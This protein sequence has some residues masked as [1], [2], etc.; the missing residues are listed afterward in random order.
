MNHANSN[1]EKHFLAKE[2]HNDC[3]IHTKVEIIT[4]S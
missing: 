2:I 3:T 4:S 1:L